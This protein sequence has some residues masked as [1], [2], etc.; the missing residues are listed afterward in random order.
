[1]NNM[2][3]SWSTEEWCMYANSEQSFTLIPGKQAYTIGPSNLADINQTRPITLTTGMGAAYIV[4]VNNNRYP[5]NVIEQSEWNSIG[6]LTTT[7][8]LPDT[9]FYDPQFPLGIINIYPQPLLP[10]NV[11]FDSRLQLSDMTSLGSVFSMPPGYKLAITDNLG[12]MLWP[13]FKQGDPTPWLFEQ[14]SRSLANIKRSNMR[15]AAA[16]YDSAVISRASNTY[17]VYTDSNNRG[18]R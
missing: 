10:Y 15:Q 1:M 7:S 3:E 8:Q 9:L 18:N 6:L 2:L 11:F 5:I 4:D 16:T 13:Y 17:N 12:I 14:A